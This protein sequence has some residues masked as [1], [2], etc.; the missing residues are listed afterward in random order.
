MNATIMLIFICIVSYLSK[1]MKEIKGISYY[2]KEEL[3]GEGLISES[4]YKDMLDPYIYD[5]Q[6]AKQ[7][8]WHQ[9]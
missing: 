8:E 2:S 4:Q 1:R 6:T 3:T 9:W 7:L 5:A